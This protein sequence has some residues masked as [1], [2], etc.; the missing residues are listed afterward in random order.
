MI[1]IDPPHIQIHLESWARIGPIGRRTVTFDVIQG[2]DIAGTQGI[3][4]NTPKAAA[5][6]AA[7][8]GFAI[9]LHIPKGAILAIGI[10]STIEP[11]GILEINTGTLGITMRDDGA[12]PKLH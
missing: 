5:V 10:I 7:T 11:T 12:S 9:L 6:A 2:A 4:V 1:P 8:I 3:G